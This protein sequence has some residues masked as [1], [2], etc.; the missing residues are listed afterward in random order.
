MTTLIQRRT[1]DVPIFQGEDDTTIE[2]LRQALIRAEQRGRSSAPRRMGDL[3]EESVAKTALNEAV[4]EA[5]PRAVVVTVQALGRKVYR[6]LVAANPPREGNELDQYQ[7]YNT[8][9]M[10]VALLEFHDGTERTIIAPEFASKDEAVAWLD[11]LNDGTYSAL[12]SAAVRCN[13]GGPVDPKAIS[14]L[15]RASDAT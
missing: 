3:P 11:N 10:A 14:E 1:E 15:A 8:D 7:G 12:F 2:G 4:Q 5:L 13:E 9:D 6:S